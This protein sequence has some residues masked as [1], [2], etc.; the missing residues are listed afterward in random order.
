MGAA[1]GLDEVIKFPVSVATLFALLG[2]QI[3]GV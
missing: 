2:Q 1:K 3:A